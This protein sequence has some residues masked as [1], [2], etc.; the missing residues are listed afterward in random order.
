MDENDRQS[1]EDS[2]EG[3]QI[4][5][6]RYT[7]IYVLVSF[8]WIFGSDEIVRLTVSNP[9]AITWISIFKGWLFVVATATVLYVLMKRLARSVS[10]YEKSYE[11][12]F[13]HASDSIFLADGFGNILDV[14]DKAEEL[15]GYWK[16][17]ILQMRIPQFLYPWEESSTATNTD[18]LK[19]GKPILAER[20]F[21]RKDG[22]KIMLETSIQSLP[23][24]R[25][26]A[27]ARDVTERMQSEEELR[28]EE[29]RRHQL[30]RQ[31]MQSQ[32]VESLGALASGIAHDFNN[33]L[34]IIGGNAALLPKR[35]ADPEKF[36]KSIEDISSA[37]DR[38]AFL[39]K[40]LL[41]FARKTGSVFETVQVNDIVHEIAGV[42]RETFPKNISI[43][44]N[45]GANLPKI[46]G[47]PVGLHLALINL[48]LS[49]RDTM[50]KGGTLTLTTSGTEQEQGHGRHDE[51]K[52][53]N[54]VE[55]KIS[56]TG[57]G[58]DDNIRKSLLEP[59]AVSGLADN[60]TS[61]ALSL[62]HSIIQSHQGR[63]TL[64]TEPGKGTT[65]TIDLPSIDRGEHARDSQV[66]HKPLLL[67]GD[68]T[69]LLV[70][71]EEML[72]DIVRSSLEARG[73]KVLYAPDGEEGLHIFSLHRT[74]IA[75]VITDQGLPG[76]E[77]TEFIRR[78]KSID[79]SA[80]VILA[81]GFIDPETRAE[82]L[83]AG[84]DSFM[85]KPYSPADVLK[86]VRRIIDGKT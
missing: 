5:V 37:S 6:L 39:V 34:S 33:I 30:E 64:T 54:F 62:V 4:R 50:P 79:S 29:Q 80:R 27:I 35:V 73:Y 72:A 1:P 22:R 48:C 86:T 78:L 11:I 47:D 65:F 41:T 28:R 32:R 82:M 12:V 71:D 46:V 53:R 26:L 7:L 19:T 18:L 45:L 77:G 38:G 51:S 67:D 13:N 61:S 10:R 66:E 24:G 20:S 31:L 69:V 8:A 9:S 36:A 25:I 3:T 23:D 81:S 55:I 14:N 63:I 59:F 40:Q 52:P 43:L 60:E 15:L 68:E 44:E 57:T 83:K 76:M 49:A 58:T 42:L 84:A 56:D 70:E 16:N 21:I 17:E 74:E 85:Q 2:F 75:A